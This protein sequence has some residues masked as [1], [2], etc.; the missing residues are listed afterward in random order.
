MLLL[1]LRVTYIS[2]SPSLIIWLARESPLEKRHSHIQSCKHTS[3]HLCVAGVVLCPDHLFGR[4]AV[5]GKSLQ[6]NRNPCVFNT[7]GA[8]ILLQTCACQE[9][10]LCPDHLFGWRAILEKAFN[11]CVF[12]AGSAHTSPGLCVS[13]A[14][15]LP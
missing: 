14:S 12:K 3:P 4:R 13:G 11:P 6:R 9:L 15:T 1:L 8:H 10:A 5:L 7:G 2:T